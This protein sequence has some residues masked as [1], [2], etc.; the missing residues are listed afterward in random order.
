M[1]TLPLRSRH[2]LNVEAHNQEENSCVFK[3]CWHVSMKVYVH[4]GKNVWANEISGWQYF[5]TFQNNLPLMPCVLGLYNLGLTVQQEQLGSRHEYQEAKTCHKG[6]L[7]LK[8]KKSSFLCAYWYLNFLNLKVALTFYFW[9]SRGELSLTLWVKYDSSW[10][11][12][13]PSPAPTKEKKRK[14]KKEQKESNRETLPMGHPLCWP[15]NERAVS[16]SHFCRRAA[17]AQT[18]QM[19]SPH[20]TV[21][22]QGGQ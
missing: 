6:E 15:L 14:K 10:A 17:A 4:L 16:R 11:R 21:S 8:K 20:P 13:P 12:P 3:K 9:S 22:F 7:T 2:V 1:S 5:Q 18:A 19:P